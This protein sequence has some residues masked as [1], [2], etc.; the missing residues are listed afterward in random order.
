[1][2]LIIA[3][4]I[5][6]VPVVNTRLC[7]ANQTI[8]T[9]LPPPQRLLL[10]GTAAGAAA[11]GYYAT[12]DVPTKFQM[13]SASGPIVRALCDAETAHKIGIFAAKWGMFPKETRP[14]PPE[15]R[16][17]LWGKTFSNPIGELLG[18]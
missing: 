18:T 8:P 16:V 5:A 17:Q 13:A 1:M 2:P 3:R 15:L 9:P 11:A 7:L 4:H 6:C 14:D 12:A 10:A